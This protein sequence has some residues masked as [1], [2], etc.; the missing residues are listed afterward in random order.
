MAASPPKRD[1]ISREFGRE[2]YEFVA[3]EY[4]GILEMVRAGVLGGVLV[5][6]RRAD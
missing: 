3:R 6:A 1:E 5:R 4:A 2:W